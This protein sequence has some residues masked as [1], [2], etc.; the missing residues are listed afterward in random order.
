M[1]QY[2][3]GDKVILD[4]SKCDP[5]NED[6]PG[7]LYFPTIWRKYFQGKMVTIDGMYISTT[8]YERY[9]MEEVFGDV[10]VGQLWFD[11]FCILAQRSVFDT[12]GLEDL[13]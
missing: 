7:G 10:G 6:T 9:H 5:N 1:K 4:F 11:E 13:I 2:K 12:S 8:S 3:K